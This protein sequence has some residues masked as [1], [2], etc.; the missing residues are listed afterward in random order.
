MS[1]GRGLQ[2][3][4]LEQKEEKQ[5]QMDEIRNIPNIISNSITRKNPFSHLPP[6]VNKNR[7]K[8][9]SGPLE[10]MTTIGDVMKEYNDNYRKVDNSASNS[11]TKF[12][13]IGENIVGIPV[14]NITKDEPEDVSFG[15]LEDSLDAIEPYI[16]PLRN[17]GRGN[18]NTKHSLAQHVV[19]EVNRQISIG[20]GVRCRG[21]GLP[22]R[23]REYPNRFENV[24]VT[25]QGTRL[26]F[27]NPSVPASA[28]FN[29]P[30]PQL[31]SFKTPPPPL[32]AFKSPPPP[33][34]AF[35]T[36]SPPPSTS[37]KPPLT[38]FSRF[39]P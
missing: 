18:L 20:R 36:P 5:A 11:S 21:R 10:N 3:K 14:Q 27:S 1:F 15:D 23:T 16:P 32:S 33:T 22:L 25:Y 9:R 31:S 8:T 2:K 28:R 34:S 4:Q 6:V 29:N 12:I 13:Q 39:N 35:K 19:P 24:S 37:N 30:P 17:R 26:R 7:K 38:S